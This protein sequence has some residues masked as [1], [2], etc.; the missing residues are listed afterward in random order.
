MR[1]NNRQDNTLRDINIQRNYLHDNPGSVLFSMGNTKVLCCATLSGGVPRFLQNHHQGWLTAEYSMLPKAT[2]TRGQREA[3][4]GKQSGRTQEIQ[5]LIGRSLRHSV[6][7]KKL[8]D[9]TIQVDC[10]VLQ[11]DGGTRT[12]AITGASIAIHDLLSSLHAK[13]SISSNPFKCFIG[14]ISV[15]VVNS[16]VLLDLDYMEDSTADTDMN[17]IMNEHGEYCEVQGSAEKASFTDEQLAK[18]LSYA[19]TGIQTLISTCQK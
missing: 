11:A 17:I 12:A 8:K 16:Q 3:V 1:A 10:D 7:L 4:K 9:M 15:G 18:M 14:A 6:D 13:K 5:R 19:K 2:T